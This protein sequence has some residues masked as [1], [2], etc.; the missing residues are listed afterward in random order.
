MPSIEQAQKVIFELLKDFEE[1]T[2]NILKNSPVAL[3]IMKIS[4]KNIIFANPRYR[5]MFE[6]EEKDLQNLTPLRVYRNASDFEELSVRLE[7]QENI[8]DLV[9]AMKTLSGKPLQVMGSFHHLR[10]L[11]QDVV[12]AW[13]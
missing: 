6:V 7:K 10:Y 4:D 5:E 11:D 12:L 13:F 8:V 2:L 1:D 9:L 3:R